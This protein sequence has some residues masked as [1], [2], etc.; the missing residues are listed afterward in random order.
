MSNAEFKYTC[1][2]NGEIYNHL[3]LRKEQELEIDSR[4]DCAV[5]LPLFMKLG[6]NFDQLNRLLHGEYAILITRE[7]IKTGDVTYWVST[8]PLSVR[9]LFYYSAETEFGVSSLL[10]GLSCLHDNV[11]RLDQGTM[12]E[13]FYEAAS[14]SNKT[15]SISKYT[16]EQLIEY[17]NEDMQLYEKIVSVLRKAV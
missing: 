2:A 11:V 13:G 4:S 17:K 14:S 6:D 1:I 7:T 10:S 12:L 5:I 9:P 16:E 3:K 8:D 15:I